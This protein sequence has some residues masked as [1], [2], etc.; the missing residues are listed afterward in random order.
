MVTE[1]KMPALTVQKFD[2]TPAKYT[3]FMRS[4][5]DLIASKT[6]NPTRLLAHL[7]NCCEGDALD[8]V[9]G[10]TILDPCEGYKEARSILQLHY[11]QPHLIDVQC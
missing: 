7:I 4:F 11:G 6:S 9:E 5:D 1:S 8:K 2:G 3:S 10:L